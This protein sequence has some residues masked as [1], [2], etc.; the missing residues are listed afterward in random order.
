MFFY[1][2]YKFL[3]FGYFFDTYF[4]DTNTIEEHNCIKPLDANPND[5]YIDDSLYHFSSWEYI[6]TNNNFKNIS[7]SC[8]GNHFIDTNYIK[9]E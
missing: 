8:C 7:Y 3:Y 4:T 2:G 1:K 9:T 5:T 6:Y